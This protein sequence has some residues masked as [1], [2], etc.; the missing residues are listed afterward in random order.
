MARQYKNQII[1]FNTQD[2][3]DVIQGIGANQEAGTLRNLPKIAQRAAIKGI[4]D[5]LI[6]VQ[7]NV[8]DYIRK[9]LV[10]RNDAFLKYSTRIQFMNTQNLHGRFYI[11]PLGNKL[12]TLNIWLN[13]EY[14]G[15]KTPRKSKYVA[16]PTRE[17]WANRTSP[18]PRRN[19]PVNIANSFVVKEGNE[20]L[21]YKRTR[22][23]KNRTGRDTGIKLMY[24]LKPSV[25]IKDTLSIGDVAYN[26][27][28]GRGGPARMENGVVYGGLYEHVAQRMYDALWGTKG[29]LTVRG[30]KPMG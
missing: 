22:K 1:K 20:R 8:R 10:I 19:R 2:F 14:G 13:L 23:T 24:T 25:R 12:D 3:I 27:A 5:T 16:V 7:Y 6:S 17:A 28:T 9:V 30:Y 18:L 15:T 11:A 29:Y 21:I 26:V 4:N